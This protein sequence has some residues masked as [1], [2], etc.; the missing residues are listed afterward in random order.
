MKDLDGEDE[1][2]QLLPKHLNLSKSLHLMKNNGGKKEGKESSVLSNTWAV[3][4][5]EWTYLSLF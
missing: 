1:V 2:V 3:K 5:S 4:M